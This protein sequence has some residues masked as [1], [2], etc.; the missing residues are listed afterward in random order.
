MPGWE[1]PTTT[2]R[3]WSW[4]P[5]S[6]GPTQ[7]AASLPGDIQPRVRLPGIGEQPLDFSFL[8]HLRDSSS[9]CSAAAGR[10]NPARPLHSPHGRPTP[11][12]GHRLSPLCSVPHSAWCIA[13]LLPAPNRS[14]P[15][16]QGGERAAGT[17]LEAGER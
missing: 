15:T 6:E 16:S 11:P 7:G 2:T 12:H 10:R 9:S 5:R 1:T 4:R 3:R 17:F 13:T 14:P 8:G